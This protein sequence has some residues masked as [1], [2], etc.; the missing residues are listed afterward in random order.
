MVGVGFP[1]WAAGPGRVTGCS[2]RTDH[3]EMRTVPQRVGG[4]SLLVPK[5]TE[6]VP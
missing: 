1:P 2:L 5:V 6:P 4:L 3:G